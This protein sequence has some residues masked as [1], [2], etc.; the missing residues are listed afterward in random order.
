MKYVFSVFLIFL[1]FV[2]ATLS[3]TDS[4]DSLK[5]EKIIMMEHYV[6]S[7]RIEMRKLDGQLQ[8]VKQDM[9][10]GNNFNKFLAALND[11]EEDIVPDDQR[12][13]RKR[14]DALLRA[15]T[16]RPGQLRFNGS[17]TTIFQTSE[18]N[19]KN[20]TTAT[21]S[22][23]IYAHT[24]FGKN[25]LLFLDFESIGGDGFDPYIPNLHSLN[26]DAGSNQDIAGF[27]RLAV[28]EAWVEF[29]ALSD[30]I[31]ITA[32]KIDLT[33]YFD[34][35]SVAND[36]TAQFY[37]GVFVNNASL[38]VPSSTP[39]IRLR[40]TL[41][42]RFFLQFGFA[43]LDNSGDDLLRDI[44]K[45]GSVGFKVFPDSDW[46]G[47]LRMY[48]FMHPHTNQA[49][50]YGTSFDQSIMRMV[51]IFARYGYNEEDL[52]VLSGIESSWS[53][54]SRFVQHFAGKRFVVGLAYGQSNLPLGGEKEQVF[55]GYARQQFN[56]WTFLSPHIQL[57]KP[58][59]Q[60]SYKMI[61]G[62]RT[63]FNF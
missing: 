15:I 22:F 33:N 48:S 7:L 57:I 6:D 5:V 26:A 52:A 50:G 55:E 47:N 19:G 62:I 23:D 42:N 34:N 63:Q 37:S 29:T 40:T 59:F 54:G 3:Q 39:G 44:F 13:R 4:F 36:E 14:V 60:E 28:L 53:L 27:D 56:K 1:T 43:S 10:D 45:I 41:L 25:T 17:A 18:I 12:S 21:G 30:A 61:F 24:S 31:N 32:G 11:E 49:K 16:Q 20:M 58:A 2:S 38:I 46:E 51:T 35:S 8:Q 9:A